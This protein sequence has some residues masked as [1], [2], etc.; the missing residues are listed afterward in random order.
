MICWVANLV[1]YNRVNLLISQRQRTS[2]IAGIILYI[3]GDAVIVQ[4]GKDNY[5]MV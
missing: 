4:I 3:S 5:F 1:E 2:E